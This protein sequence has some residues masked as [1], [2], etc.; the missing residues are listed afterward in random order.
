MC[1]YTIKPFSVLII[2]NGRLYGVLRTNLVTE[3][4][5]IL[6]DFFSSYEEAKSFVDQKNSEFEEHA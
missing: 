6:K 1:N 4:Y 3:E 5:I 2:E